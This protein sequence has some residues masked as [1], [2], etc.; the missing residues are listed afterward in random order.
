MVAGERRIPIVVTNENE[1]AEAAEIAVHWQEEEYYHAPPS[2]V[3]QA[4]LKDPQIFE[5]YSIEHFPDYYKEFGEMLDWYK[6]WDTLFDSSNP[7]FWRWFVGGELNASFNCVDRHLDAYKNKAALYFV[8]EPEGEPIVALTYQELSV[9]VNELAAYLRDGLNLKR[10][11]R[12]T[13]HMPMVPEL[14]VTMLACARLGIIHSVVF[15]GFSAQACADRMVDSDSSVL[16]TMD[17][18]WRD[19]KWL[20]HKEKADETVRAA[21][22]AGHAV[23]AVLIFERYPGEYR[24][25]FGIVEDRDII[26]NDVLSQYAGERVEP[27]H[28]AADDTLFLMYTS[29]STG[30]PKAAQHSTGG[31]LSYVTA[32]SKWILDI[33]PTDVYWCMA[34][35]GWITGHSFI[36]YGPLSLG[37]SSIIYEGV[38]SCPDAGR[39][40]RVAKRLDVNIFH[41]SPTAIRSLR[42]LGPEEPTKYDYN[43]KL[44]VT[45]GEPIE[46]DVWRWYYN[47]V[48]KGNVAIVDTWWQTEN[49]GF[50]CSTVPALAPMKPGS[51]GP[52][53]PGIHPVIY[54]EDGNEVPPGSGKGGNICIRN[55]WPGLMMGIWGDPDRYVA[56]YYQRYC[57]DPESKDWQDWPYFAGDGAMQAPDGYYRILGRIDDVINVAGHRLGTKE[58]ESAVLEVK[59]VAEAAVIAATDAIKG[60]IPEIYV[61]LQPGVTPSE[62]LQKSVVD[63]IVRDIGPI[64][65]PRKV[66]LVPDLPKT[67]S[68]KIMRRVLASISNN[69]DTGDVTSLA[70]PEIVEEIRRTV[71]G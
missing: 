38:P 25:G 27:E 47:T 67:R 40:W 71:S 68:G 59:G 51:T 37:A 46:P 2:F 11:D 6:P 9:Q 30:K 64:A 32:M 57:K 44:M 66:W 34:D 8:P 56:T 62:Q 70:N 41:T 14:A 17:G 20:D 61:T 13:I 18:Y 49:G 29:G 15:G 48:G 16:I 65:R 39:P 52:G 4:N 60:V 26:L 55:P 19:G 7:P 36:V 1:G 12:V 54:D 23:R 63:V 69:K 50:L 10:G 58:I 21:G 24:S 3:E 5:R 53:V 33:K 43:F 45:V 31:Y 42:K 35:I 28:M 22:K